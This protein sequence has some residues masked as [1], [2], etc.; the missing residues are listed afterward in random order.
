MPSKYT[1]R[2][3]VGGGVYHVYNR[4]VKEKTLF[5]DNSDYETFRFYLYI[6][7]KPLKTVLEQ[8]ENLPFRL[9]IKNL[10]KEIDALAYCLMPDHFHL[11]LKQTS[12]DGVSKLMKQVTNAYTEYYNKKYHTS[13]PLVQG[14]YKATT[15]EKDS[16]LLQVARY[17][18]L[19][20]VL[21]QLAPTAQEYTW[22]SMKEYYGSAVE[23]ICNKRLVLS[24][25]SSPKSYTAFVN[26]SANFAKE[27]P[28]LKTLL[29]GPI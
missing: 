14:R 16:Y 26:D 22:S 28:K 13:G 18:H 17:I 1:V 11:L 20:P 24:Y 9:Q 29:I 4:A 23:S 7:L 5:R 3:F 21:A 25:Y 19:D 15:L 8:Y 6:Y 10:H 27:K 12:K 2:S